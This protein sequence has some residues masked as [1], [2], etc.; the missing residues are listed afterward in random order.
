M[1]PMYVRIWWN[2]NYYVAA[3][4][5]EV[6]STE[7]THENLSHAR[8]T[9]LQIRGRR[10][11][12]RERETDWK[13]IRP[14]WTRSLNPINSPP[15]IIEQPSNAHMSIVGF[16]SGSAPSSSIMPLPSSPVNVC[17][18]GER[19]AMFSSRV[20]YNKIFL[21]FRCAPLLS[22]LGA[23]PYSDVKLLIMGLEGAC[24]REWCMM[25]VRSV[26]TKMLHIISPLTRLY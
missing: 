11:L 7:F 6:L 18:A 3:R 16:P 13:L 8:N 24:A 9:A 1:L 19:V 2:T 22:S 20:A 17:H 5:I 12:E 4:I 14:L 25:R 26:S 15:V 21:L 10:F 23:A